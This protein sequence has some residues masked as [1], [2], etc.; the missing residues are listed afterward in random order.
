[1]KTNQL[2]T[3]FI[4]AA[5]SL[6]AIGAEDKSHGEHHA[7]SPMT[8]M[9]SNKSGAEF[10]AAFLGM[11][12]IHHEGGVKMAKVGVEKAKS[13][14]L[15]GMMQKAITTQQSEIEQMT[16][17]LRQ[18]HKKSPSDFEEPKDSKAKMQ[19]DMAE[20]QAA[21][22]EKFDAVFSAKMAEHHK[23]AIEMGHIAHE[24]AQHDE[25]KALAAKIAADQE[26]ERST[27][28]EIAK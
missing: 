11:M 15:K 16:A 6:S 9:I 23:A 21:S 17:W 5:L 18:W 20:V 19:K 22:G 8:A 14:E 10:E 12:T 28:L 26:K 2:I 24:K 27:L 13:A 4:A 7:S 1:M 3:T 25:V